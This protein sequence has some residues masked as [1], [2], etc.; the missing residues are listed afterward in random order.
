[1]AVTVGGEPALG[2][3]LKELGRLRLAAPVDA[4]REPDQRRVGE[5][6]A[7]EVGDGGV[8]EQVGDHVLGEPD[9]GRVVDRWLVAWVGGGTA[10]CQDGENQPASK[11]SPHPPPLG[12]ACMPLADGRVGQPLMMSTQR[13]LP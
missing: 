3:P 6:C 7:G 8:L 5:P 13:R 2:Q 11:P 12:V 4:V 10:S 9:I 1:M